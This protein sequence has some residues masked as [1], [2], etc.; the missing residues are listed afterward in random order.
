V[1]EST[2]VADYDG[3][4]LDFGGR[5]RV[6]DGT[7]GFGSVFD[8]GLQDNYTGLSG[9]AGYDFDRDGKE[10][11]R[12]SKSTTATNAVTTVSWFEAESG[13]AKIKE[14]VSQAGHFI[15]VI[16]GAEPSQ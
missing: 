15:D 4:N 13:Y 1:I 14:F 12:I 11:L 2:F 7:D 6:L 5:V 10:E 9:W 3:S 16:L 8:T